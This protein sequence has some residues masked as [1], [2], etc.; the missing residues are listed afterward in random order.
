MSKKATVTLYCHTTCQTF[1]QTTVFEGDQIEIEVDGSEKFLRFFAV[2]KGT[3]PTPSEE[4]EEAVEEQEEADEAL[5]SIAPSLPDD[6]EQVLKE[7]KKEFTKEE[8]VK[9]LKDNGHPLASMKWKE[10]TLA[11]K[12]IEKNLHQ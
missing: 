9:L 3:V 12:V 1:G 7:V 8:M 2:E 10:E 11:K 4:P 6:P 5:V